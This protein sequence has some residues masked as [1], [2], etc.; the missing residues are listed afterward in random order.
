[1]STNPYQ[2]DS[3]LLEL[4]ERWQTGDFTRADEQELQSLAD[5]DEFRRDA[6][7]GFWSLP[8]ANHAAHLASL[9]ARLGKRTLTQPIRGVASRWMMA[10][11]AIAVLVVAVV[12]LMPQ[13]GSERESFS[14]KS[15][16]GLGQE[17]P[18]ASNLPEPSEEG[19]PMEDAAPHKPSTPPPPARKQNSII[20]D[21]SYVEAIRAAEPAATV[22]ERADKPATTAAKPAPAGSPID[23]GRLDS[24]DPKTEVISAAEAQEYAA[25]SDE[26]KDVDVAYGNSM[27]KSPEKEAKKSAAKKKMP[28]Q[29]AESQPE[30]GWE[31][32]EAYVRQNARLPEAARQNNVS[33]T[34]RM[35]FRLNNKNQPIDFKPIKALGF[36]CE[37][38]AIRLIQAYTWERGN[39]DS[40]EV[41]IPFIR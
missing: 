18:I 21:D 27:G 8:E 6:V 22:P 4:L 17:S 24:A 35:Q 33:G 38:A 39:T 3:R 23:Q 14:Q 41:D 20:T 13:S 36:G 9:K 30:G 11:A 7:A 2:D 15:M 37:E 40:L 10:A 29:A 26:L 32:F 1:M 28:A 12:W 34:V 5:S 31:S 19:A 16:P 25:V